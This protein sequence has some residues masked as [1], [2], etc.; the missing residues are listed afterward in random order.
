MVFNIVGSIFEA[1]I[2]FSY[3]SYKQMLNKTFGIF[4]EIP[5]E[6]YLAFQNFL[7]DGHRIIIVEWI[8]SCNHFIC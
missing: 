8:N 2:P 7:I 5:W 1:S 3:I 6:L 4:I